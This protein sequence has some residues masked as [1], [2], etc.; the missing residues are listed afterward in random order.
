MTVERIE[1]ARAVMQERQLDAILV[2]NPHSR[3]YLTGYTGDDYPPDESAGILLILG[4]RARMFASPNNVDWAQSEAPHIEVTAWGYP[5]TNSVAEA[6]AE[7]GATSVGFEEEALSVG[8][9]RRLTEKAGEPVVWTPLAGAIERLRVIKD[10]AE[11]DILAEACRITDAAFAAG[12]SALRA[13]M[14]EL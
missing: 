3:R 7:A 4:D 8:E 1:R 10:N 11:I 13:G 5:W 6:I 14:T 9:F 2:S 12:E